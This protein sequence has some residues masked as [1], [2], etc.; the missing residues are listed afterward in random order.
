MI[1]VHNRT[2]LVTELLLIEDGEIVDRKIAT[3]DIFLLQEQE[4]I[5]AYEQ[6]VTLQKEL[7]GDA[8]RNKSN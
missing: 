1:I 6:I 3:Q 4:F 2:Q 8:K 7:I 5:K